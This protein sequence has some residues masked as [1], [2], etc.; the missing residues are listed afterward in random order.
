MKF[1]AG[2]SLSVIARRYSITVAYLAKPNGAERRPHLRGTAPPDPGSATRARWNP[3]PPPFLAPVVA[4][5]KR[6]R[7]PT[8]P[9]GV[10]S[11]LTTVP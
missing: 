10:T 4:A 5:N 9:A 3:R 1:R 7:Y 6:A 11:L 2:E 8:G